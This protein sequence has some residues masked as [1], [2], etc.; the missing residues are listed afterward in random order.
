VLAFSGRGAVFVECA[1]SLCGRWALGFLSSSGARL[2]LRVLQCGISLLA[3]V[4]L[5]R[6]FAGSRAMTVMQ[7][8][9]CA[10]VGAWWFLAVGFFG[11]LVL[12]LVCFGFGP[13]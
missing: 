6:V 11:G 12:G 4:P 7:D 5:F 3:R 9:R 10:P 1:S 13:S 8:R 2:G